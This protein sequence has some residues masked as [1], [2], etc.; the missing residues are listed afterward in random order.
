[1]ELAVECA[2]LSLCLQTN[3]SWAAAPAVEVVVV[4]VVEVVVA[5]EATAGA[6]AAVA[7]AGAVV[8]CWGCI[9]QVTW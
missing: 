9:D 3:A 1:M 2:V 5:A 6:V 7:A 4:T 8:E